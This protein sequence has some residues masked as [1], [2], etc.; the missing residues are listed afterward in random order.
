MSE[1]RDQ[2][3]FIE[4]ITPY[5]IQENLPTDEAFIDRLCDGFHEATIKLVHFRRDRALVKN[6]LSIK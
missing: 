1:R 6:N 4:Y 2:D 5:L 3:K